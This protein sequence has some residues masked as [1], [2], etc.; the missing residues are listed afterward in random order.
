MAI[1]YARAGGGYWYSHATW[2]NSSNGPADAASEPIAGD[3][4]IFDQ[5]S[6]AV[7]LGSSGS[8]ACAV[9]TFN[10]YANTLTVNNAYTLSLSSALNITGNVSISSSGTSAPIVIA[11]GA[12]ITTVSNATIGGCIVFS[13]TTGTWTIAGDFHPTG[14]VSISGGAATETFNGD[15]IYITG[16]L[17]LDSNPAGTS[18]WYISGTV[19][20]GSGHYF[21][22]VTIYINGSTTWNGA[23]NIGFNGATVHY[24]A[25][26][27]TMSGTGIIDILGNSTF[28]TAGMAW[29]NVNMAAF[30]LTMQSEF[31]WY[32]TFTLSGATATFSGAYHLHGGAMTSG[33]AA[34][35]TITL[36]E[37]LHLANTLSLTCGTGTTFSGNYH[38]YCGDLSISGTQ[39][40]TL[41]H[42]VTVSGTTTFATGANVVNGT[43]WI[44]TGGLTMTGTLT[45]SLAGIEFIGGGTWSGASTLT[46]PVN[47]NGNLTLSGTVLYSGN[48]ITY[49]SGTITYGTSSLALGASMTFTNTGGVL[50]LYTLNL[51]GAYTLTINSNRIKCYGTFYLPN[52]NSTVTGN[53]GLTASVIT[54]NTGITAARTHTFKES[55]EYIYDNIYYRG[56]VAGNSV[57]T[58]AHASTKT[59]ITLTLGGDADIAFLNP[60]RIDSSKG[61]SIHSY[62][63][64]VTDSRNW[65]RF[66]RGGVVSIDSATTGMT[67]AISGVT[68]DKNGAVLGSCTCYLFREG[69][70]AIRP[71]GTAQ[72]QWIATQVSDPTTGAYSFAAWAG[73]TYF[74]VAFKAGATPVMDVTDRTL[75]AA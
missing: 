60:T 35:M 4:A 53:A 22:A 24:V 11:S 63:V 21:G 2:S 61:S 10:N 74:V 46:Y 70:S 31:V 55:I 41:V 32:G 18:N 1:Y 3:T 52:A 7:T 64:S 56:L 71:E 13:A 50:E 28:D 6:G 58:S 68:R 73:S 57:F 25:G 44:Y 54:P 14:T 37:E 27:Q 69:S 36:A 48:S 38:L 75:T 16:T 72:V 39:T 17:L 20:N 66:I 59:I 9:L 29:A 65:A 15:K 34:S 30:T 12:T 62:A 5:Y 43:Y 40:V 33:T 8:P 67:L 19:T 42:D 47:I 26:T 45:G 23:G 51:N 49:T